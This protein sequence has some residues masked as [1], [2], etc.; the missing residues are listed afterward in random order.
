M[1]T[2][3]FR[4]TALDELGIVTVVSD[5]LKMPN[6]RGENM[7]IPFRNG[8]ILTNKYFDQRVMTLGLEVFGSSLQELEENADVIK[9]LLGTGVGLLEQTLENGQVRNAI[10]EYR[11]DTNFTRVSPI[12]GK[13]LLDFV[14]PDPFFYSDTLTDVDYV[15]DES[16]H[17]ETLNNPGTAASS[18]IRVRLTAPLENTVITH[19]GNNASLSYN[20]AIAT[21]WVEIF[22]DEES[23]QLLAI[24]DD[25]NNVI[26]NVDYSG[27]PVLLLEAGDNPLSITDDVATT[28]E[29]RIEFYPA[30]L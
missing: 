30:N 4:G 10:A 9:A 12:S 27:D 25:D 7:T 1:S 16:P 28:G 22:L 23:G 19:T 15:I 17:L 5:S 24:D 21:G 26:D 14:L 6:R 29:V 3:S 13:M 20:A 18:K 11:A 8:R 2:W